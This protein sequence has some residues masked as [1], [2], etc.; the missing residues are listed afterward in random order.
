MKLV[1]TAMTSLRVDALG[2]AAATGATGAASAGAGA[3]TGA[4]RSGGDCRRGRGRCGHGGRCGGRRGRGPLYHVPRRD[5]EAFLLRIGAAERGNG[6]SLDTRRAV[7]ARYQLS[8]HRVGGAAAL[9]RVEE[10]VVAAHIGG[11]AEVEVAAHHLAIKIL[12]EPL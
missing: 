6:R 9:F 10:T 8:R 5:Q 7:T 12:L 1:N 3:A 2:A 4:G 11:G